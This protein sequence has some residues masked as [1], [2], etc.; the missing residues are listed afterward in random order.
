M[1]SW[2]ETAGRTSVLRGGAAAGA[3]P[4]RLD[5]E[6]RT[7]AFAPTYAVDARL[8]DPHLERVVADAADQGRLQGQAQGY[9]DGYAAGLATAA[10][11]A[12]VVA[13]EQ[14]QALAA[15]EAVR[16][17]QLR[18]AVDVLATAA[19]ALQAREAVALH[20][21]EDVVVGLALDIARAVLDRELEVCAQ[22]GRE[23]LARALVLAPEGA[24]VRARLHPE[25]VAALG[26]C[27]DL[28]AGRAVTVVA[29]HAVERGGCIADAAGR[30]IDAQLGPALARVAAVLR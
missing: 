12:A 27:G 14:A 11:E 18:A 3:R 25:D 8:T 7:T 17:Q 19:Q 23:A 4:A 26:D 9:A 10:A 24:A 6:L 22:P 16:E 1:S 13:A 28:V 21:I 29:D 20:E 30:Q 2:S 15:A 5:A